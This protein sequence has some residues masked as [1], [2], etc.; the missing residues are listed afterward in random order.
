MR[1]ENRIGRTALSAAAV[2]LAY[3]GLMLVLCFRPE[4]LTN[5]PYFEYLEEYYDGYTWYHSLEDDIID[6]GWM[7]LPA[8]VNIL[9]FASALLRARKNRVRTKKRN[10]FTIAA[11][12]MLLAS[13]YLILLLLY[14]HQRIMN[15]ML[16]A[17]LMVLIF[18]FMIPVIGEI[19]LVFSCA[20]EMFL[21][22][23]E[24]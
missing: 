19:L 7:I 24:R 3:T 20:N 14:E 10:V 2:F 8:F 4:I 22:E 5:I 6:F 15:E 13:E 12:V 21:L 18:S 1:N 23:N 17:C 9:L 11:S 16:S